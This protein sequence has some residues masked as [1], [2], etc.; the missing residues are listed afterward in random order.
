MF[1]Q[2]RS[3]A[4]NDDKKEIAELQTKVIVLKGEVEKCLVFIVIL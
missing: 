4:D 1:E 2:Q 3:T